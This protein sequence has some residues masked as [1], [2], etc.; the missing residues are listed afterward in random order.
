MLQHDYIL[1]LIQEFARTV[2][3]ALARARELRDPAAVRE[4]EGAIGGLLEL[5]AD[6][7]M[8]L[9]PQSLVTMMTLAGTG[10]AVAGYVSYALEQLAG[11]MEEMGEDELAE[12][13]HEQADAVA[14]AFDVSK[15]E[16]P[17]ELRVTME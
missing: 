4:V 7:A 15:E 2:S 13:R 17:E 5:D 16:V 9:A 3:A 12:L 14:E 6:T 10:D 8:S 1:K 11:V